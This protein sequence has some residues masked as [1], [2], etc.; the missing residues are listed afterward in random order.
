M[1]NDFYTSGLIGILDTSIPAGALA[2]VLV[3]SSTATPL[4]YA[5]DA[6]HVYRSELTDMAGGSILANESHT[7]GVYTADD[8][9]FDLSALISEDTWITGMALI[10][11]HGGSPLVDPLVCYID[12]TTDGLP[13]RPRGRTVTIEWDS[14]GIF[15]DGSTSGTTKVYAPAIKGASV[16]RTRY[17]WSVAELA[18]YYLREYLGDELAHQNMQ[19][20]E[21]VSAPAD[22]AIDVVLDDSE[23]PAPQGFPHIRLVVLDSE[24]RHAVN[25]GRA[26]ATYTL[27][28]RCY[29][30]GQT[31]IDG[32]RTPQSGAAREASILCR[33]VQNVLERRLIGSRGIQNVRLLKR[34]RPRKRSPKLIKSA[35]VYAAT[36]RI[37]QRTYSARLETAYG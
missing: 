33:A 1:A 24:D 21:A 15:D 26:R 17:D 5:F 8:Y 18:Q 12:F 6:A 34:P 29:S 28:I 20:G 3:G 35:V 9:T 7:A 23:G 14:R 37:T 11:D 30:D 31:L 36:L 2:V 16:N 13:F 10:Y 32:E 27:E 25:A 22:L 4:K 19:H